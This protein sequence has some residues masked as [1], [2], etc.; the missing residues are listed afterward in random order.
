MKVGKGGG[1]PVQIAWGPLF[2]PLEVALDGTDVYFTCDVNGQGEVQKV[3]SDGTGLTFLFSFDGFGS[4][5]LVVRGGQIDIASSLHGSAILTGPG[6]YLAQDPLGAPTGIAVDDKGVYWA[7]LDETGGTSDLKKV[8]PG[9]RAPVL[10]TGEQ[11]RPTALA[12]DAANIY[13]VTLGDG[14]GGRGLVRVIPRGGGRLV[15]IARD[16]GDPWDIA[17]DATSVYWVANADGTVM[18][19]R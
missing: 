10:V 2:R 16:Q 4:R 7:E 12:L 11:D 17:V 1:T 9:D 14:N 19:A 3:G 6:A 15:T 8:G 18:L 5:R 13:W